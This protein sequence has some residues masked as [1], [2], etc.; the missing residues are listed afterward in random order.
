MAKFFIK[1]WL[2]G[3]ATDNDS[4]DMPKNSAKLLINWVVTLGKLIMRKLGKNLLTSSLTSVTSFGEFKILGASNAEKQFLLVLDGTAFEMYLY[5]AG[6]YS[7]TDT[8]S[9]SGENDYGGTISAGDF[10]YF[11]H[12][13]NIIRAGIWSGWNDDDAEALWFTYLNG[14]SF[15]NSEPDIPSYVSISKWYLQSA[16]IAPPTNSWFTDAANAGNSTV[17][18]TGG[19]YYFRYTL[20]YDGYQESWY[21][22]YL[23]EAVDNINGSTKKIDITIK[24]PYHNLNKRI[25]AVNIYMAYSSDTSGTQAET[26]YYHIGK[27]DINDSN[28][29]YYDSGELVDEGGGIDNST[30]PVTFGVDDGSTFTAGDAISVNHGDG[31]QEVMVV[32]SISTNDLTC[33]RG[34]SKQTHIDN[35]TVYLGYQIVVTIDKTTSDTFPVGY[36]SS[37]FDDPLIDFVEELYTRTNAIL[38]ILGF[39][40]DGYT[41]S[42]W[43][44]QRNFIIRP[45]TDYIASMP[46]HS[47][48]VVLFSQLG[49][50]D[51]FHKNIDYID[52]STRE[53]DPCTGLAQMWG[54][55]IVFKEL[56]MFK[57]RFNNSGNS[58]DWSIDEHYEKVGMIAP[59]SLAEG[60][61]KL[62]FA[63]KDHIY[64]YD[65][66]NAIP[67]TKDRIADTYQS[68]LATSVAADSEYGN[69]Y[70]MYDPG[71]KWYILNFPATAYY[72]LVYDVDKK[73][74]HTWA[75]TDGNFAAKQLV[76]GVDQ[77]ILAN[78]TSKIFE[79][80]T[81]GG[82]END[83]IVQ[84][85]SQWLTFNG[86][87]FQE[88]RITYT[89][90][91]NKSHA[92]YDDISKNTKNNSSGAMNDSD[93]PANVIM[94]DASHGLAIGD[95]VKIDSEILYVYNVAGATI[96]VNRAQR[97]TTIA[98]HVQ[99]SDV[100]KA[101][102]TPWQ[103]IYY[104]NFDETAVHTETMGNNWENEDESYFESSIQGKVFRIFIQG[105]N[106]ATLDLHEIEIGYEELDER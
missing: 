11:K 49:Q 47:K 42:I 2:G 18:M 71:R 20:E 9:D 78:G 57:I 59:N 12:I 14:K 104:K 50:P 19:K 100:Y 105:A 54:N 35:S 77:Q 97:G 52:L 21:K 37:G 65:G 58:L 40:I 1:D 96:Q 64:M 30:D 84:F 43:I 23:T 106:I 93:D 16:K 60:D 81:T 45:T 89:K 7:T 85:K 5:S 29:D 80:D 62:F 28:W 51:V 86:N 83:P 53:G 69:I 34:D 4:L 66:N 24:I 103:V 99:N 73:C 39:D 68:Y 38:G 26:A 101:H 56:N 22:D 48:Q 3:E 27:I 90:I 91:I 61:G 74:W 76:Q 70:G 44:N 6:S 55:L 8:I 87:P 46:W 15:F 41:Q 79:L 10:A 31:N 67:L 92:S 33:A 94:E 102:A 88:K 32:T 72:M 63:G 95:Y 36:Q 82:T 98:T 17:D 75:W 25:S 13:N